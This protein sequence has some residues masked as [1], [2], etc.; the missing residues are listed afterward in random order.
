VSKPKSTKMVNSKRKATAP[1]AEKPKAAPL[2]AWLR[3][4]KAGLPMK[5]PG[6][7]RVVIRNVG[8]YDPDNPATH[9]DP[10]LEGGK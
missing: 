6:P 4:D 9:Y 3:G 10:T 1:K 8:G 5:P 7:Y 2:P